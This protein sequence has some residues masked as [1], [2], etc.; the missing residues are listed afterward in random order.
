MALEALFNDI[1]AAIHEKDGKADGI[2]AEDFPIRIRAIPTGIGGVWL[3][4]IEITAPPLKTSY[5]VGDTFDPTGMAVYAKYSNGQSM[6]VDHSNLTFDPSGP[7]ELGVESVTVNFQWGL[8]VVSTPQPIHVYKKFVWWSPKMMSDTTPMPYACSASSTLSTKY[9]VYGA[10][11]GNPE[12]L[13]HSNNSQAPWIQF[14]FG[15]KTGVLGLSFLPRINYSD[16]MWATGTIQGSDDGEAWTDILRA[17]DLPTPQQGVYREHVF[18]NVAN[19]RY[20]RVAGMKSRYSAGNFY[21]CIADIKFYLV[22][23]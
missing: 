19:Y 16:Q 4:S 1:A 8:K 2:V 17:S 13:W 6:Y 3:E 21:V 9:F 18:E 14:D 22:E 10:F 7:L 15:V 20:Y 5:I 23:P 12:T 11:D